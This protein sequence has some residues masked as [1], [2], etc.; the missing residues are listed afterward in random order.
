MFDFTDSLELVDLLGTIFPVYHN[1]SHGNQ[2]VAFRL[3]QKTD[4]SV[5]AQLLFLMA[6]CVHMF[7]CVCARACVSV[8]M[9]SV[10]CVCVY[11]KQKLWVKH[12]YTSIQFN[13]C[14]TT[15]T[16]LCHRLRTLLC[17]VLHSR[18]FNTYN[19]G[20]A[21]LGNPTMYLFS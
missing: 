6:V 2:S 1:G 9:F 20:C 17:H 16:L 19:T 13:N 14:C 7:V 3:L 5:L 21:T 8:C 10:V 11:H 15:E 18:Q 12:H 4:S